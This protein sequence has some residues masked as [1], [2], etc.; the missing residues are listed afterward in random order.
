MPTK[1]RFN[2]FGKLESYVKS[3][4]SLCNQ[5]HEVIAQLD[6]NVSDISDSSEETNTSYDTDEEVDPEAI[7]LSSTNA[8]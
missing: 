2:L 1:N 8:P 5:N 4:I 7:A 3:E 6:G